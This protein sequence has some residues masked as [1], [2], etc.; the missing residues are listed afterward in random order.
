MVPEISTKKYDWPHKTNL[1]AMR[2]HGTQIYGRQVEAKQHKEQQGK[3]V[4]ISHTKSTLVTQF[5]LPVFPL[6][7]IVSYVLYWCLRISCQLLTVYVGVLFLFCH[8]FVSG[9]LNIS[10]LARW[11]FPLYSSSLKCVHIDAF[12]IDVWWNFDKMQIIFKAIMGSSGHA[13]WGKVLY[14]TLR[15]KW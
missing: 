5:V 15:G 2:C 13:F 8:G 12:T 6:W 9:S 11:L 3:A 7:F 14:R 10:L 1:E 4:C